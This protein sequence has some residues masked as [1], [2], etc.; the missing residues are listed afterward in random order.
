[1]R[2]SSGA[3]DLNCEI[4]EYVMAMVKE[5]LEDPQT[6]ADLLQQAEQV[7]HRSTLHSPPVVSRHHAYA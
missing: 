4:C 6:E 2:A 5:Q 1:M 7:S 3:D